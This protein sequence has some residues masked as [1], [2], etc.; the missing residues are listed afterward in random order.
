MTEFD[1]I[2]YDGRS[3]A[4]TPVRVRVFGDRLQVQGGGIELQVPIS[5]VAADAPIA[6]A[7]RGLRLPGGAQLRTSDP[8]VSTLFARTERLETLVHALER[9]WPYALGALVVIAAF[10]WWAIVH[11]LP[12]A[13]EAIARQIPVRADAAIGE[14]AL[15]AIDG[16]MCQPSRLSAPMQER[17]QRDFAKLVAGLD[18]G[19]R[20][21]LHLRNCPGIGPNAFALPGGPIVLT[22][23]LAEFGR[24]FSEITGVLAHEV[25]HVRLR[26]GLRTLLQGAGLVALISTLAGDAAAITSIAVTLPTVL[27]QTGYSREFEDEADTFALARMKELGISPRAFAELLERIDKARPGKGARGARDYF[28]T[29][30]LTA[31]RIER[32]LASE[33]DLDRCTHQSAAREQRLEECLKVIASGKRS[34][35]ELAS[36]HVALGFVQIQLGRPAEAVEDL[37]RGIALG[38]RSAEA[39][40]ALAW[41]LATSPRD[42]LRDGARA[43]QLALAACELSGWKEAYIIDTLAAAHAEAGEFDEAVRWQ[44]KTLEFPEFE[45]AQG[46]AARAR[47]AL[48]S[49]GKAYREPPASKS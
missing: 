13:S 16:R 34:A 24:D 43:K 44:K 27:L 18:D 28:A 11:G 15:A 35:S 42:A 20:Y 41:I 7:P 23:Q 12:L 8:A 5:A 6:S 10:A 30:P 4:R 36:A 26:H 21:R 46:A 33:S 25:A 14:H 32:A 2:Y 39:H 19:H 3:A 9:R 29:H 1:A 37:G 47:L 38:S 40:N 49:S 17:L 45:K 22:D 48:Y 31:A